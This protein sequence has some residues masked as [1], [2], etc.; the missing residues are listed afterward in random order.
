MRVFSFLC[1]IT[2]IIHSVSLTVQAVGMFLGEFC[3]LAAFYILIC[4]DKR[5]PEPRVNRGQSFNPFLFFPPAMCDMTATSIMYVGKC[6][7][8]LFT[9]H[10]TLL[11]CLVKTV[12]VSQLSTWRAPQVSR[13]SVALWS[14]SP[15]YFLWH[16]W[17][18]AWHLIS[19]SAFL[20]PF[21]GWW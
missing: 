21:W 9:G 6:P 7:Q 16:F 18:V 11:F 13:C 19:G 4:H 12:F 20:S 14:S 8:N 10:Q 2:G 15:V 17:G 3:C 5:R 1:G